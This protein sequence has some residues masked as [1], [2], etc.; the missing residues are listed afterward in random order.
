[1]TTTVIVNV[2]LLLSVRN[3]YERSFSMAAV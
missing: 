2:G 3:A 1:V